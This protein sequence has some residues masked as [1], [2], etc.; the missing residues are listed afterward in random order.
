MIGDVE[1][2]QFGA[3][4]NAGIAGRGVEFRESGDCGRLPGERML[5]T[6]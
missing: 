5:A 1:G 2:Y 4:G 3:F 6:A